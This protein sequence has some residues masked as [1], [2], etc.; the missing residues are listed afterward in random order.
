MIAAIPLLL[1]FA[2]TLVPSVSG[3]AC[4]FH[5]SMWGFNVTATTFSYDNRPQTPLMAMTFD[6]WW[7][8]NHLAYP[9]NPG[10]FMDLPAGGVINTQISCDKGATDF[11]ASSSGGDAGA[12]GNYVCPGQPLSEFH[13]TGIDDLGGCGL[14]ITYKSDVNSVQPEDFSIFSV[15]KTCV[16]YLN[17]EF[18]IPSNMPACPEGGCICAWFWIHSPDSG[19]EQNYMN[20]F[21][22]QVTGASASTPIGKNMVARRCGADPNNGRPNADLGN[23]TVGPKQP[24]YWYQQERNNMFEGTYAPPLYTDLYYP[25]DGAQEDIFQDAYIS[26]LGP[27]SG[28][29]AS[30]PA[31]APSDS[32]SSSP[33]PPPP[34]AP[35]PPPQQASSDNAAAASAPPDPSPAPTPEVIPT[36]PPTPEVIPTPPPAP[37]ST[38]VSSDVPPP[39][40]PTASLTSSL[41]SPTDSPAPSSAPS[42]RPRPS[43]ASRRRDEKVTRGKR[44]HMQHMRDFSH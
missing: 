39:V 8:H 27:G 18:S 14:G 6:Q 11:F 16:W 24:F 13:T 31:A 21:R 35:S 41:S 9:P 42:C 1:S 17:T 22:C 12:G 38:S 43:G 26:S 7:F 36:P 44:H 23:C 40:L 30:T 10:D 28:G 2:A 20:G 15:N 4:I 5:P 3:H 29:S 25:N 32:A 34:A 33:A 37:A 19:G